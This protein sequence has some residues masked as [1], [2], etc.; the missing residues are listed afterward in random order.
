MTGPAAMP[1]DRKGERLSGHLQV[2]GRGV[3]ASRFGPDAVI[4]LPYW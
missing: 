3:P 2:S 4:P 1:F